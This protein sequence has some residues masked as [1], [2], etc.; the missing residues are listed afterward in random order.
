MTCLFYVDKSFN[1]QWIINTIWCNFSS[2][3]LQERKSACCRMKWMKNM[4]NNPFKTGL[5]TGKELEY[6]TF[7][8][9]GL[10]WVSIPQLPSSLLHLI[11]LQPFD[12][13]LYFPLTTAAT[14]ACLQLSGCVRTIEAAV[15]KRGNITI[16]LSSHNL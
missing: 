1:F 2:L 9:I 14:L 8:P 10:L 15:L 6:N 16:N 12:P 7:L 4:S 3:D 5:Q 13:P 11:F